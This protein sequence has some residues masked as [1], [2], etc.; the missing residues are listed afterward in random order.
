MRVITYTN[1]K[2]DFIILFF[3]QGTNKLSRKK[4]RKKTHLAAVFDC[5]NIDIRDYV[6]GIGRCSRE[7]YNIMYH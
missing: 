1:H 5:R 2:G 6:N 7:Q 4:F 3:F